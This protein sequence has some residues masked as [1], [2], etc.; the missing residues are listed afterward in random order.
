MATDTT[1]WD[2]IT[3]GLPQDIMD[4]LNNPDYD[5]T[6][7]HVEDLRKAPHLEKFTMEKVNKGK[8]TV[9]FN[10]V[11]FAH[12]MRIDNPLKEWFCNLYDNN[13]FFLVN[14]KNSRT[15]FWALLDAIEVWKSRHSS[16]F[17]A[18]KQFSE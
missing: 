3:K 8:I 1:F 14:S 18:L 5:F 11:V 13:G 17:E 9:S 12:L 4:K 16:L 10:G 7:D 2:A 15:P 6:D